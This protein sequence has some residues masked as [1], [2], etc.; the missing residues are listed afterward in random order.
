MPVKKADPKPVF[1]VVAPVFNEIGC[2]DEFYKTVVSVMD[3]LNE[4]WELVLIEDGSTDGTTN[5]I[6][7]LAKKDIRVK[8]IILARN[9][10]HQIAVTAGLDYSHGDAVIIMDSDLQDPPELILD[11]IAKWREGYEVVYAVRR[12]REGESWF[13]LATAAFFYRLIYRITEVKIPLIPVISD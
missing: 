12:K 2:I 3:S 4:P 9:F 1:S 5:K 8:P 7:E 6:R 10:G 13:K 11:L